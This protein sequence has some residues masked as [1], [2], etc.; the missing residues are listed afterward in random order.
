MNHFQ[1]PC[2]LLESIETSYITA[3]THWSEY[4]WIACTTYYTGTECHG[5]MASCNFLSK[6][7]TP[8]TI[9]C[10]ILQCVMDKAMLVKFLPAILRPKVFCHSDGVL[11]VLFY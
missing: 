4:I 7:N 9:P 11:Q 10:L 2:E 1:T 3:D 5:A 8:L 6:G